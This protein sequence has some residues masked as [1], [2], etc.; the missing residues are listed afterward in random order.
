[1]FS[2]SRAGFGRWI[3]RL[4][5]LFVVGGAIGGGVAFFVDQDSG[6]VEPVRPRET[7]S[8]FG[9][10]SAELAQSGSRL[11]V[12]NVGDQPWTAC[13]VDLNAGVDGGA[14]SHE[15][16]EI[17]AGQEVTL[18]LASFARVDGRSFDPDAERVLV[19]DVHCDTPDGMAHFTGGL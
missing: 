1:M 17:D 10:L 8:I 14:F 6:P 2:K 16:D 12:K 13:M 9:R 18:R 15:V 3:V 11:H 5:A 7:P 4:V 19:V